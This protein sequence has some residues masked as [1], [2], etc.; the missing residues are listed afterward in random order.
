M[1]LN[2]IVKNND[3]TLAFDQAKAFG[4]KHTSTVDGSILSSVNKTEG[5]EEWIRLRKA[6]L[7]GQQVQETDIHSK[8][9]N[10]EKDNHNKNDTKKTIEV[11]T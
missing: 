1:L 11:K 8:Y 3:V 4:V 5:G 7:V 9:N 6:S 2:D 10:I